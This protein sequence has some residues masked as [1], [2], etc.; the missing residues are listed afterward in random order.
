MTN[1]LLFKEKKRFL[2]NK[3]KYDLVI[4]LFNFII[5]KQFIYNLSI[6]T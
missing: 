2:K 5:E 4:N 6:I 1:F 3:F